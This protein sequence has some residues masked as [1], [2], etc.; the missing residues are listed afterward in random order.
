[1]CHRLVG[2]RW[3]LAVFQMGCLDFASLAEQARHHSQAVAL[4]MGFAG[5]QLLAEQARRLA[6]LGYHWAL[7]QALQGCQGSRFP[8]AGHRTHLDRRV[9]AK[10]Q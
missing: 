10:E 8:Q 2:C 5:S 9:V 4:Q 3:E 6:V 1:M 7:I